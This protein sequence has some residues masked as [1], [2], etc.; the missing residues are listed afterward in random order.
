MTNSL[1]ATSN[2]PLVSVVTVCFN[3]AGTL[4][5]TI[6]SVLGQSYPHIEYIVVDGGST[7]GSVEILKQFPDRFNWTS[8]PDLG[9][10]DAMNKGIRRARGAWIHIL[11]ADDWYVEKD[12]L[13]RAI[14]HLDERF[15]TYFDLLRAYSDGRL[16]LQSRDVRPWMLYVSAFLP[17]PSL[18]VARSQYDSVGLYDPSLRIASDHDLI[19][20][21]VQRFPPKHVPLPLT[22]MDQG[23]ISARRLD[24]TL[25]EFA[26]VTQRHGLPSP[27]ARGIRRLKSFWWKARAHA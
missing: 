14:P 6:E 24:V 4:R 11:N 25:D 22:V 3:A 1:P 23:G 18:I 13:Q 27:L 12:A 20:R 17:H 21:L 2:G 10:Y 19:L 8:G 7:D 9:M 26:I 15:T 16:V 5:R